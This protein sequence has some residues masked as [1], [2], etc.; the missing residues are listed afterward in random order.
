MGGLGKTT[1]A[2]KIYQSGA[3]RRHFDGCAWASISQQ[4]QKR[5]VW[6][7]IL[8]KL[9]SPSAE[10]RKEMKEKSSEEIARTLYRL[11]KSKRCLVILDDIWTASKWSQ[12]KAGFPVKRK[13]KSRIL[14]TTRK[15]NVALCAGRR[16]TLVYEL[17]CLNEK[18]SWNLFQK[19]VHFGRDVM[20]RK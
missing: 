10:E 4:C 6:E 1:L 20:S 15:R 14:I 11:L 12:L 17:P 8:I 5:D 18:E 13:S 9:T 19:K 3:I 2:R 16:Y 7:G